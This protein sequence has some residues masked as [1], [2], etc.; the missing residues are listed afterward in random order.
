M[1]QPLYLGAQG[2][3][4]HVLVAIIADSS[5]LTSG[6]QQKTP[7]IEAVPVMFNVPRYQKGRHIATIT[8]L[9]AAPHPTTP[10]FVAITK[11][12]RLYA[13]RTR[14]KCDKGG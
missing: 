5:H 7:D 3:V 11:S 1:P 6:M 8:S 14:W 13:N 10:C 9:V 2:R 12:M 4:L